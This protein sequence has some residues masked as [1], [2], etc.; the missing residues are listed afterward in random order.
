MKTIILLVVMLI[1]LIPGVALST[2][3]DL[4]RDRSGFELAI[5]DCSAPDARNG[6]CGSVPKN[7]KN[8]LIIGAFWHDP[9][10]KYVGT[11]FYN[12]TSSQ[13]G[14]GLNPY[15]KKGCYSQNQ[16]EDEI[17]EHIGKARNNDVNVVRL[18]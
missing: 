12:R 16:I 1:I 6:Y 15:M 18:R 14:R 8:V 10:D 11:K 9:D 13:L 3:L 7:G 5:G 2:D 17:E 4:C